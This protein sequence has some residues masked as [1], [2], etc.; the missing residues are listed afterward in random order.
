MIPGGRL[1]FEKLAV[2]GDPR[3]FGEV[4]RAL[5]GGSECVP[6]MQVSRASALDAD[7]GADDY[8]VRTIKTLDGGYART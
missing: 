3:L 1:G 4:S 6:I 8:V 7:R 5:A 2:R